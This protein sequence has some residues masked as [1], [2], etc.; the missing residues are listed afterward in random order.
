MDTN[1]SNCDS[2]K[3]ERLK[4]V[5][6]SCYPFLRL[7]HK[8]KKTNNTDNGSRVDNTHKIRKVTGAGEQGDGDAGSNM[9]H[10]QRP[11]GVSANPDVQTES[12]V[13]IHL[14]SDSTSLVTFLDEMDARCG[15]TSRTPGLF[16]GHMSERHRES[17]DSSAS[18]S[19]S[20][21][22]DDVNPTLQEF[23]HAV[24]KLPVPDAVKHY[25]LYYR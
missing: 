20:Y 10:D 3:K 12:R 4:K 7:R 22:T 15:T 8:T 19:D 17:H 11:A 16:L 24:L 13:N 14:G 2:E 25:L 5:K 9:E 21:E 1:N 6:R 23:Y 18:E